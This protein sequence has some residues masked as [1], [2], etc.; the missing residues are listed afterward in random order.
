MH[1]LFAA[2]LSVFVITSCSPNNSVDISRPAS[3][4]PTQQEE[5]D[6]SSSSYCEGERPEVWYGRTYAA[7]HSRRLAE[8]RASAT[9]R[10]QGLTHH[11]NLIVGAIEAAT[12]PREL[13]IA[14]VNRHYA[15][16]DLA[17]WS[18]QGDQ[19]ATYSYAMSSADVP[20]ERRLAALQRASA[21]AEPFR[22]GV[23]QIPFPVGCNETLAAGQ[24]HCEYGLP[25]AQLE[26]A[27]RLGQG[28]DPNRCREWMR[29]AYLGGLWPAGGRYADCE[30][31]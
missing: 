10:M 21:G 11:Q 4:A 3:S 8:T 7:A 15:I 18:D 26:L 5:V 13:D 22:R 17:C 23:T 19:I 2:A 30:E 24:A 31:S 29:R 6:L 27:T 9:E 25:E 28:R 12:N 20:D 16:E 1:S 14:A